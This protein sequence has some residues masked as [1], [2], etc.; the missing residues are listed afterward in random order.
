MI[1]GLTPKSY[2]LNFDGWYMNIL[3]SRFFVMTWSG[4]CLR[5]CLTSGG[6]MN[7]RASLF[8]FSVFYLSKVAI[9]VKKGYQITN[10]S[11]SAIR[12]R[13]FKEIFQ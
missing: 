13:T 5:L 2:V 9:E 8:F 1:L 7:F 4:S 3:V 11:E 6:L 12:E 10:K